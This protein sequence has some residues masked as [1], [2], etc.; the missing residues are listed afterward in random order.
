MNTAHLRDEQEEPHP[1]RDQRLQRQ[2]RPH[3][4]PRRRIRGAR[5]D[6][7][8]WLTVAPPAPSRATNTIS[9]APS[10]AARPSST[11][12]TSTRRRATCTTLGVDVDARRLDPSNG[13][14]R[15]QRTSAATS[16]TRP[17]PLP[18]RTQRGESA[19]SHWQPRTAR[20]ARRCASTISSTP[21]TPTAQT[22]L[23]ATIGT[24]RRAGARLF[25]SVDYASD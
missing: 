11:A 12:T 23:S 18:I 22:S 2:Q 3:H 25:L 16:S 15:R 1:A 24:S 9:R 21:P 7:R 8:R 5:C 17:T 6:A 10:T 13:G 14:A 19:R 20:C 4:A